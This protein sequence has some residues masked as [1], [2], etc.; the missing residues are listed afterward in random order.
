MN[1]RV[2][3]VFVVA[4]LSSVAAGD[5]VFD[6]I[7]NLVAPPYHQFI[8]VAEHADETVLNGNLEI[9]RVELLCRLR[10]G[11]FLEVFSGTLTMRLRD[12]RPNAG[13]FVP[14]T[15]FYE[16]VQHVVLARGQDQ[17]ISFDVPTVAAPAANIRTSWFFRGDNG[18]TVPY[19]GE[20]WVRQT[21]NAAAVGSF[22]PWA[23]ATDQLTAGAPVWG[24]EQQHYA[25]RITSVP[26][27]AGGVLLG[28]GLAATARRGRRASAR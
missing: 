15:V 10:S 11:G 1:K 26:G 27:P 22:G 18:H 2:W 9:E 8:A 23:A 21:A 3:C 7:S 24:M 16:S 25:I 20:V 19:Y 28:L 13:I 5:G 4:G 12:R 14:G 6:S 17:I